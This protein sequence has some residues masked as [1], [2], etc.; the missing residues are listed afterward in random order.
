MVYCKESKS[1][2]NIC[3][4]IYEKSIERTDLNIK[5]QQYKTREM[6]LSQL[7][8]LLQMVEVVKDVSRHVSL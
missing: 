5:K 4:K 2:I 1:I 8:L 6:K 3:K 7:F